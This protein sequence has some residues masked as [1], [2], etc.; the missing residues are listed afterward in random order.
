VF[1]QTLYRPASVTEKGVSNSVPGITMFARVAYDPA[2]RNLV[3]LYID[4]GIGFVGLVPGRPLDRFG[5]AAAY[6][7]ISSAAR[8]LDVD[9][10]FFTGLPTPVRS[11]ETLLEV[12][13]EAHIKPGWL[14]QPF[15]QYV[16]HPAGGAVN[17]LDPTGL[18]PLG[19][20][21]VFGLTTTLRY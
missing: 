7:H 6:M 18:A 17:P 9:N 11:A 19:N 4:G 3:D 13:Y 12:I 20:A 10:Q 16:I 21:A 15:F 1:E 2:D 14:L 8:A 5:F